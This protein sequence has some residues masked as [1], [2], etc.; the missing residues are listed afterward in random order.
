MSA[1]D[2]KQT[3][4]CLALRCSQAGFQTTL[5][6]RDLFSLKFLDTGKL[7]PGKLLGSQQLVQLGVH[8]HIPAVSVNFAKL[9]AIEHHLRQGDRED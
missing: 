5:E 6:R 2:P 3:L 8:G 9:L 4:G 1:F 7:F